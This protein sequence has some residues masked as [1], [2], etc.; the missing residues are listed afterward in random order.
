MRLRRMLCLPPAES[1][2]DTVEQPRSFL[3][4]NKKVAWTVVVCG[5]TT[6]TAA[7]DRLRAAAVAHDRSVNAV[8]KRNAAWQEHLCLLPFWA[9]S[10]LPD[11]R[12]VAAASILGAMDG[13][14]EVAYLLGGVATFRAHYP[15]MCTDYAAFEPDRLYPSQ[16]TR[17]PAMAPQCRPFVIEEEV[18]FGGALF[19]SSH[20]LAADPV[21]LAAL[22][23]THVVNVTPDHPN[24][25]LLN[26]RFLRIPVVDNGTEDLSSHFAR[27]CEFIDRAF[28]REGAVVLVH[29]RHGQSRSAAVVAR[30]LMHRDESLD[31]PTTLDYLREC[32][33]RV[34]PNGGFQ[35]QLEAAALA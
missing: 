10:L 14:G 3:P 8:A 33:P 1:P 34:R 24:A 29:C 9:R 20:A 27:A 11:K 22:G 7:V 4:E 35:Q 31:T 32:R 16:I 15:F 12:A 21:V 28:E 23:V 13:V 17:T 25:D 30:W 19:L 5:D 6:D 2:A 26:I 18:C